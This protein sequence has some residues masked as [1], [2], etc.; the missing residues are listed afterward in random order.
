MNKTMDILDGVVT[1]LRYSVEISDGGKATTHVTIFQVAGKP[2]KIKSTEIV[3]IDEND[4]VRVAGKVSKGVFNAYAYVNNTTGVSGNA[5]RGTLYVFGVIFPLVGF[6][7]LLY[8]PYVG[9]L[10]V[11]IGLYALYK[12]TQIS[13]ATT[14]LRV[15][16]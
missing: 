14:M 11:L 7:S 3:L 1:K 15:T 8:F 13:R 4:R 9:W 5:G 12:A 2:V 6:L 10:F 16:R